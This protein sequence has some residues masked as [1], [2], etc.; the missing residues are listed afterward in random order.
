M[1]SIATV[2]DITMR[3]PQVNASPYF[4]L[5][6]S[7]NRLALSRFVLSSHA[8]SGVNRMRAPAGVNTTHGQ[9]KWQV[10]TVEQVAVNTV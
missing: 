8:N 7:S 4:V 2:P 3:S 10:S 5:M 9:H 6:G 1:L